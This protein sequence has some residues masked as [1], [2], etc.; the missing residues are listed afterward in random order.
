MVVSTL[1]Q[2]L[3]LSSADLNAIKRLSA[4]HIATSSRPTQAIGL[5]PGFNSLMKNSLKVYKKCSKIYVGQ[6]TEISKLLKKIDYD[7][8]VQLLDKKETGL[9]SFNGSWGKIKTYSPTPVYSV[10]SFKKWVIQLKRDDAEQVVDWQKLARKY[11]SKSN[12]I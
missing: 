12:W 7:I 6:Q 10:S 2:N 11:G 9:F 3:R 8:T 5:A 4:A 1:I